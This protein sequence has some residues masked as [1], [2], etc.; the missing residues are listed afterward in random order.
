MNTPKQVVFRPLG[1]ALAVAAGFILFGI[2]PILKSYI[3]WRLNRGIES[4]GVVVGA[5]IPFDGFTYLGTGL[6]IVVFVLAF[7]AWRGKPPQVRFVFQGAVLLSVLLVIL[8]TLFR[9]NT[10]SGADALF[11]NSGGDTINAIFRTQVPLQ[12]LTAIYIIWYCNRAPARA[13]YRQETLLSW[14]ELNQRREHSP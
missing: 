13:F 1:L 3:S 7:F 8:E 14:Q 12:I 9:L 2:F 10:N 4:N 5:S 6:G 11:T